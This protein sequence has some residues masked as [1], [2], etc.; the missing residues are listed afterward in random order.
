M[1]N[2]IIVAAISFASAALGALFAPW[3]QWY[4]ESRKIR[5]ENRKTKLKEWRAQINERL[6]DGTRVIDALSLNELHPHLSR[7][8]QR[9]LLLRWPDGIPKSHEDALFLKDLLLQEI[10]KLEKKWRLI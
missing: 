8:T 7:N 10:A 3:G 6:T 5:A 2:A 4:V 9:E 1:D